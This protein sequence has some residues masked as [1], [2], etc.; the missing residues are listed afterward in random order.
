MFIGPVDKEYSA[1]SQKSLHRRKRL[2]NIQ[3]TQPG[4]S[5]SQDIFSSTST[6]ECGTP[7]ESSRDISFDSENIVLEQ[8]PLPKG[9]VV[10]DTVLISKTKRVSVRAH[11]EILTQAA[12][13]AGISSRG[14]SKSNTHR[15][16]MKVVKQNA[17]EAHQ[18]LMERAGSDMILHYDGKTV[19]EYTERKKMKR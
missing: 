5:T 3:E 16:G 8:N 2:I 12:T 13:T 11:S 18:A 10:A 6:S 7:G 4:S 9:D 14:M 17:E 19:E 15:K 1:S